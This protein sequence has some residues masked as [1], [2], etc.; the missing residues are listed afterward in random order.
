MGVAGN[1]LFRLGGRATMKVME[2][3]DGFG[4]EEARRGLYL[5]ERETWAA[6]RLARLSGE[7]VLRDC[8]GMSS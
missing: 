5:R 4:G 3:D 6:W 8:D 7:D 1:Q 2:G